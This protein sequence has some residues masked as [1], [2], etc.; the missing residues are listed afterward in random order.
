MDLTWI[1]LILVVLLLLVL[2]SGLWIGFGLMLVGAFAIAA[3][4]SPPVGKVVATTI[5]GKSADWTMTALPMFIWMG[6]ILFRSRLS[7]PFGCFCRPAVATGRADCP[8]DSPHRGTTVV[9]FLMYN[10][11]SGVQSPV[12]HA[13]ACGRTCGTKGVEIV[14]SARPATFRAPAPSPAVRA[15]RRPRATRLRLPPKRCASASGNDG[16][17]VLRLP[18]AREGKHKARNFRGDGAHQRQACQAA[19]RGRSLRASRPLSWLSPLFRRQVG[20]QSPL[21]HIPL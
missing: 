14:A 11:L 2:A 13:S 4:T 17:E 9:T 7:E 21:L 15:R 12:R 16:I 6:E 18:S 20:R 8:P 5:W 19:T 10:L 1:A 3:F